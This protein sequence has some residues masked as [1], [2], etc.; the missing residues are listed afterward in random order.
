MVAWRGA[1]GAAVNKVHWLNATEIVFQ[2]KPDVF[3]R[4]HPPP[5]YD[6]RTKSGC[7]P[8]GK[9]VLRTV[10]N[11]ENMERKLTF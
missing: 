5:P 8:T 10:W 9:C 6:A 11:V 7:L 2:S 1:L 3:T 4:L